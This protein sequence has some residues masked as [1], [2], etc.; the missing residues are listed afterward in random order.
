MATCTRLMGGE[1]LKA[2]KLG[3]SWTVPQVNGT[4]I[5]TR[6]SSPARASRIGLGVLPASSACQRHDRRQWRNS[7]STCR[8]RGT[9]A[10]AIVAI[11]CF[12][13]AG[14]VVEQDLTV[15]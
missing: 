1:T 13:D 7:A 2:P 3:I 15:Q 5:V 10:G 14:D 4:P 6:T 11:G 12:T 8:T 9:C